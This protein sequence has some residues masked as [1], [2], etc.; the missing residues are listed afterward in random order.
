MNSDEYNNIILYLRKGVY[1]TC[2]LNYEHQKLFYRNFRW[3]CQRFLCENDLLY[4][5]KNGKRR[6][7]I[8][9][10]EKLHIMKSLH[11]HPVA[12]QMGETATYVL[13]YMSNVFYI[14]FITENQA[15]KINLF[16]IRISISGQSQMASTWNIFL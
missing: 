9:E 3:K 15:C 11:D 16:S 6:R 1:P 4:I 2:S 7:V 10:G 14:Y 13:F 5:M 8:M 12:G